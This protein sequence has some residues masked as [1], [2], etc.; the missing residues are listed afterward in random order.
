MPSSRDSL[1]CSRSSIR[2]AKV[3]GLSSGS[4]TVLRRVAATGTTLI[5]VRCPAMYR[6]VHGAERSVDPVSF[7]PA[8][9]LTHARD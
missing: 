2:P 6:G 1:I 8:T 4:A 3:R 7:A 5:L 9:V